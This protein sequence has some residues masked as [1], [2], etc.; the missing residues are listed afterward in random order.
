MCPCK[1]STWPLGLRVICING[2]VNM[3]FWASPS[4]C[5]PVTKGD[6]P[7]TKVSTYVSQASL[8]KNKVMSDVGI[9]IKSIIK[10]HLPSNQFPPKVPPH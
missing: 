10:L 4:P 8:F 2:P 7:K 5:P 1:Q 6:K 3:Y 9:K